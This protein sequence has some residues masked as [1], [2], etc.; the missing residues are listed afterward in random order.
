MAPLLSAAWHYSGLTPARSAAV[1]LLL[2]SQ[3]GHTSPLIAACRSPGRPS[4]AGLATR[5]G[6]APDDG[7]LKVSVAYQDAKSERYDL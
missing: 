7:D 5:S 6:G 2:Q 3:Q 1:V 4:A